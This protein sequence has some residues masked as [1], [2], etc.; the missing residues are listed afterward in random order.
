[1][2]T[3]GSWCSMSVNLAGDAMIRCCTYPERA[4]ILALSGVAVSVSVTSADRMA[5]SEADVG[6]ARLLLLAARTYLAE[7]ER[8]HALARDD[9]PPAASAAA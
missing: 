6:N 8:L 1:M 4:P 5:V 7:C 9:G 3:P 2:S